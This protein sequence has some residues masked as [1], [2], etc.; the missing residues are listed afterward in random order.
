MKTKFFVLVTFAA[1]LT[2]G[3]KEKAQNVIFLIGDGMGVGDVSALVLSEE[4]AT[5]FEMSPVIG[6]SET[7][8]A[9]NFVTDSPAGGTAL[10][11]GTRTKNGYLGLGPNDEQLESVMKKAQQL[12]KKTGIVVNTV[13]TEATPGAFYAGVTSRSQSQTIALQFVDSGVDVA[14]GSG[15]DPFIHRDDSLDLTKALIDKGYDVYLDWPQVKLT[16]SKKYVGILPW[17]SIHRRNKKKDV[18]AGAAEGD[19]VCIAAKLAAEHSIDDGSVPPIDPTKYLREAVEKAISSLEGS[20]NGFFLMIESAIIDGYGHNN[21]SEGMIEEMKEYD[22]TLKYLVEYTKSHPGTLLV[23]TADHETGGVYV[24][25]QKHDINFERDTIHLG[26]STKGHSG[27]LVPIFAYG[28]CAGKFGKIMKNCQ[29][30]EEIFA[31]M[32]GE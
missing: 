16:N 23:T 25:Y 15:L 2:C 1:L 10:A 26:F 3:C 21:D 31:A 14:I 30:P 20:K 5:A 13:L 28:T 17:D 24:K 29:V 11:T 32:K 12:G 9:D 19:D 27:T 22:Q 7:G 4:D 8:S 6:F 18:T